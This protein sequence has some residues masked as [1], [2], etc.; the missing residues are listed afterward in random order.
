MIQEAIKLIQSAMNHLYDNTHPMPKVDILQKLSKA[1]RL[2]EAEPQE[3]LAPKIYREKFDLKCPHCGQT[4]KGE[5]HNPAFDEWYYQCVCGMHWHPELL[6]SEPLEIEAIA[7]NPKRICSIC[8]DYIF[9][10]TKII[11]AVIHA[12]C[13]KKVKP[14]AGE[15]TKTL[16]KDAMES[17][18]FTSAVF[19]KE[20]IKQ[21]FEACDIIDRLEAENKQLTAKL[22]STAP[23]EQKG[24]AKEKL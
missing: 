1:K 4:G 13:H 14:P 17:L 20:L 5:I 15:F 19:R 22:T 7:Q 21:I 23:E 18:N 9:K 8:G 24:E 16:R 3:A 10:D 6:E 11:I 12:E 2:L